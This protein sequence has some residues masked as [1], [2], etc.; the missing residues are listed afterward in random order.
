MSDSEAFDTRK[1]YARII[2]KFRRTRRVWFAESVD[3]SHVVEAGSGRFLLPVWTSRERARSV[4]SVRGLV[5]FSPT[6]RSIDVWLT[7]T[8]KGLVANGL[9]IALEPDEEYRCIV[10]S[11]ADFAKD[12]DGGQFL[13]GSDISKIQRRLKKSRLSNSIGST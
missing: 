6:V 11:S 7:Q 9:D 13:Q 1:R 3:T 8:T 5:A 2:D 12:L 10:V 4:L